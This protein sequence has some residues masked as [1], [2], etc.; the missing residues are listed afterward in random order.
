MKEKSLRMAHTKQKVQLLHYRATK[1]ELRL[2]RTRFY[3]KECQ[4]TFNAQTNLV[5]E[6]YYL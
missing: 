2:I 1:T 5:D 6:N 4:S 3:C